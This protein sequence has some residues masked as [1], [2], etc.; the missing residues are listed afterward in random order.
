MRQSGRAGNGSAFSRDDGG[1]CPGTHGSPGGVDGPAPAFREAEGSCWRWFSR[2]RPSRPPSSR[3][4][5]RMEIEAPAARRGP[6]RR[7]F[8]TDDPAVD[9]PALA[10]RMDRVDKDNGPGRQ[11]TVHPTP[12]ILYELL[13][14]LPLGP[15]RQRFRLHTVKTQAVHQFRGAP[16]GI[17]TT[18][19]AENRVPDPG[20]VARR[21]LPEPLPEVAF[22]FPARFALALRIRG[23]V[24]RGETP[25]AELPKPGADRVRFQQQKLRD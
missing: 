2:P 24:H 13:P 7:L 20:R 23:G 1:H 11:Q 21:V 16:A 14:P 19:K 8:R 17:P 4:E 3:V 22:L 10:L 15:P 25:L 18:V 12:V 6:D 9:R 5:R